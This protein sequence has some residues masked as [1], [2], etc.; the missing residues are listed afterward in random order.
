MTIRGANSLIEI[1]DALQW[2]KTVVLRVDSSKETVVVSRSSY[3]NS[4]FKASMY[5][6]WSNLLIIKIIPHIT[7]KFSI[8][9]ASGAIIKW[10]SIRSCKRGLLQ[11]PMKVGHVLQ[12]RLNMNL[13]KNVDHWI[14]CNVS[15][16][17]HL[18][19]CV[20]FTR[21]VNILLGLF[22]SW[23]VFYYVNFIDMLL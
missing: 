23:R 17:W 6:R 20:H 18:I 9:Y 3:Q 1:S 12:W 5:F 16:R 21:R 15:R 11:R 7:N 22:H 19:K 8:W 13:M 2:L 14:A 10:R 4:C